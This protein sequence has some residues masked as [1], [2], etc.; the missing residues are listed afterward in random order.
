MQQ[1]FVFLRLAQ[2]FLFNLQP[3]HTSSASYRCIEVSCYGCSKCCLAGR[4]WSSALWRTVGSR[5]CRSRSPV[6][7]RS[8]LWRAHL[9]WLAHWA[10]RMTQLQAGKG[11]LYTRAFVPYRP[12]ASRQGNTWSTQRLLH[13]QHRYEW[14]QPLC[15]KKSFIVPIIITV[16]HSSDLL[17]SLKKKTATCWWLISKGTKLT[18]SLL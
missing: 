16:S 8:N 18:L 15:G 14:L 5:C 12:Q 10:H 7:R 17:L 2:C 3:L 9:R 11:Q 4:L 13:S 6:C 1:S